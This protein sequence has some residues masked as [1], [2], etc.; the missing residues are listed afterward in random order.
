[1]VGVAAA[2]VRKLTAASGSRRVAELPRAPLPR[3]FHSQLAT[4]VKSPPVGDQWLHEI[5]YDGFR[6]GCRIDKGRV[7]LLSRNGKDW[8]ARFPPVA[9]AAEELPV[10]RALF[11]GEV[12]VMLPDGRTSFQALQR[13]FGERTNENLVYLVF[14]LLHVDGRD[15]ASAPLEERKRLLAELVARSGKKSPCIRYSDHVV[16]R[17]DEFFRQACQRGLEGIVS[18]RR[19]V[20][21]RP[22]RND[23]WLKTKCKRRQELV[24]GGFTDPE[25]SREGIG[26]LLV[27]S[28]EDGRLVFAGKVGTGFTVKSARE[29]RQ[30]LEAIEQKEPPF[31]PR[32]PGWL[33]RNAHWVAPR[34][35]CEVEFTEWT[36][37][38]KI[39]HPVFQG[40]RD[41]K[42][43]SQ[44]TREQPRDPPRNRATDDPPRSQARGKRTSRS[45]DRSE[46]AGVALSHADRV[47][48]PE[49]GLTKLD[50]ARYYE[51]I[52]EWVVPHLRGR[53]LTLV[54]CPTG[55]GASCFYMKH[56]KL[57]APP[58]LRRVN[59][60][61]KKK[62]GE[63]L[64]ADT[65]AGVVSLVQMDVLEIH[66]WNSTF[67]RMEEPDRIVIDL[68]PGPHVA[69]REVVEAARV[70]RQV[71]QIV[72]LESFVKTTGGK[73]LHVVVPLLP[74]RDW[75][76][77]FDLSRAVAEAIVRL[78]PSR[79]T[80]AVK[81]AGRERKILI[82]YF[83]NNR[84]NTS[85]AAYSTRAR[86]GAPVSVPL[87]WDELS[88]ST[89]PSRYTV[90]SVPTRLRRLRKD[91]WDRY[92]S[93]KQRMDPSMIVKLDSAG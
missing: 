8:T 49:S 18:K 10:E 2:A 71:L 31:S 90:R 26:A 77:C 43:A 59:I 93:L 12:A 16:G 86:P 32:P 87:S 6:I 75:S 61:E 62:V 66:T 67:D 4:L 30:R 48:Y 20:A 39:R 56:S 60:Q 80:V 22:G 52:E 33:G 83:R 14:D 82:D 9:R 36:A 50:L 91:P 37:E 29:L 35:V 51:S 89:E 46:V 15:V 84:T 44:V 24:I 81:K 68:D 64:I 40:L 19:D 78:D 57:W 65:I 58:A 70:V 17:G 34:L 21:Y 38:G 23:C 92:V 53:P 13:A 55:I 28:Y 69:W 79:F 73:G 45:E 63:Y 76:E 88:A 25:G 72:R 3:E 41:D 85:V 47:L 11:D 1:V 5:K 74:E 54:R 42:P 7:H 27:G